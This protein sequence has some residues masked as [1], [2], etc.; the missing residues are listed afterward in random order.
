M[1]WVSFG[2]D[3]GAPASEGIFLRSNPHPRAYGTFARVLGRYVR[4][5]GTLELMEALGK[6]TIRPARRLESIAP[7]MALKGRI[8]V[9]ADADITIFNPDAIIDTATFEDDLS[10]SEGVF[11]VLVNGTFV[12]RDGVTVPGTLPGRPIV[13]RYRQ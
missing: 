11:H 1:S 4:E 13:G 12:V 6:M 5:R 9:G 2:S 10:F 8:Q 7:A 3:A